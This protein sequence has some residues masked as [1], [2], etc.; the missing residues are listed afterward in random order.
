M[1]IYEVVLSCQ[2]NFSVD[3]FSRTVQYENSGANLFGYLLNVV[4]EVKARVQSQS[5][6]SDALSR[7]YLSLPQMQAES[8]VSVSPSTEINEFSLPRVQDK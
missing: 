1:R 5:Q 4:V 3:C 6:E 7:V 2:Q 8:W